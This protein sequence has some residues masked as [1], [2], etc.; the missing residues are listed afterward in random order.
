MK[1]MQSSI[2][3]MYRECVHFFL[4]FQTRQN[5]MQV[6]YDTFDPGVFLSPFQARNVN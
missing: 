1:N 3:L 5:F 6:Q 2:L 4:F